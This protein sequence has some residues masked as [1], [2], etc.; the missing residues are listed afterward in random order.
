MDMPG[1][2]DYGK[3]Y[4]MNPGAFMQAQ[5]QVDLASQFQGQEFQKGAQDLR[6][7]ELANLFSEQNDP[8]RLE[9]Q[10]LTNEG[11]G[12]T[13]RQDKVKTRISEATEG[14]Q[15]DAAQKDLVY[16]ASK[17]ELDGMEVL[18]QRMAYSQ[19]PQER[20]QGEAMLKLHRDFIKLR[21]EQKFTAGE[22]AKARDHAFAIEGQ[23]HKN[24]TERAARLAEIKAKA[25]K[26]DEKLSTDQLRA[27]YIRLA[28]QAMGQGDHEAAAMY[29]DQVRYITQ[30]R[31][32][33]RP[34][35]KAGGIDTPAVANL[36]AVPPKTLPAAPGQGIISR[37]LPQNQPQ[38][39]PKATLVDVQK[40]Y[41]GIPPEKLREAY[42]KKFGVD[43]Q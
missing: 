23:R 26:G 33:E 28:E 29:Q 27:K 8:Q 14:L 12:L 17:S 37:T 34:D 19:N 5:G 31:A 25:G 15:L 43:L 35:P 36:P 21:E 39:T 41:P 7:K 1:Y 24:A 16:K 20:A 11:M 2:T 40:M 13:N 10:R 22:N 18:G 30:M 4:E 38:A 6:T 9:Q 32:Y 42:K 3:M